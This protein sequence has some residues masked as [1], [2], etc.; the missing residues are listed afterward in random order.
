MQDAET[1]ELL[2]TI[3]ERSEF[4]EDSTVPSA[5]IALEDPEVETQEDETTD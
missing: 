5:E 3:E 1:D 2:P 4:D